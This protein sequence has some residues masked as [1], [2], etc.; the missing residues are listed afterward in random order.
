MVRI[1]I[2]VFLLVIGIV[3]SYADAA[4]SGG[5]VNGFLTV[6]WVLI[7]LGLLGIVRGV[8]ILSRSSRFR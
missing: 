6:R 8:M 4:A 5:R 7:V 1:A 2:G 3:L